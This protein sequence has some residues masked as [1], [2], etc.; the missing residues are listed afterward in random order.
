[1][2]VISA[3]VNGEHFYISSKSW[4]TIMLTRRLEKA[5]VWS[6]NEKSLIESLNNIN[7]LRRLFDVDNRRHIWNESRWNNPQI[8]R[9]LIT[10]ETKKV[11]L[12]LE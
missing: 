7:S 4:Y 2:Y 9:P 8:P 1:M 12:I 11:T 3:Q 10:F 5:K 6:R